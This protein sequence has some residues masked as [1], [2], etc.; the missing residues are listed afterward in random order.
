MDRASIVGIIL[1][2]LGVFG[3]QYLEGGSLLSLLQP[4]AFC[5]VVIGTLGAVAL[6]SPLS[7]LVGALK[8][9]RLVLY[10]P[11]IDRG[12]I[13]SDLVLWATI[14]R[15]EGF[16]KLEDR[17]FSTDNVFNQ[18][19][20]RLIVDGATAEHLRETML[21]NIELLEERKRAHVRVWDAAG[22]YAPTIGILG[23]VLGLIHVMEN[24]G[25]PTKLGSGI[26]VAFVATVYGVGLANLLFLPVA[27]KLKSL[28]AYELETYEMQ[29]LGFAMIAAGEN[30][31]LVAERCRE[32]LD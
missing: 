1:I 29:T 25:D 14:A 16:L 18:K 17:I 4:A 31:R 12:A 30:P 27:Q 24:L 23:A 19:A 10:P 5:I 20:L 8:M 15:K 9:I 13:L 3:G 26:A 21:L 32:Y 6:Q 2:V 11:T 7:Q 28:L 22:G